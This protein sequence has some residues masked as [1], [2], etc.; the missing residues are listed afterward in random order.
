MDVADIPVMIIERVTKKMVTCR[1]AEGKLLPYPPPRAPSGRRKF[2]RLTSHGGHTR[3]MGPDAPA[4]A[5]VSATSQK[6]RTDCCYEHLD[7]LR[8]YDAELRR[9]LRGTLTVPLVYPNKA[10]LS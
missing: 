1:P 5:A 6:R 7:N 9:N 3:K 8:I 4:P 10:T 2:S